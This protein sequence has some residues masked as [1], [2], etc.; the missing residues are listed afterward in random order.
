MKKNFAVVLAA[1]LF[2]TVNAQ[3]NLT[4]EEVVTSRYRLTP[5]TLQDLQWIAGTNSYS[6]V[7]TIGV[8]E[9][10]CSSS[11]DGKKIKTLCTLVELNAKI[12]QANMTALGPEKYFPQIYWID[13]DHFY[14]MSQDFKVTFDLK[15][16]T[17]KADRRPLFPGGA[18]NH[19]ESE[20]SKYTAFTVNNNLYV[21]KN[22]QSVQVTSDV[23]PGIVNGKSYHREE[24]GISKGTFWSPSGK[25]LAFARMDETMVTEYPIM[26]LGTL[27]AT[28]RM[29][30]YP[31]AGGNSHHVTIGVYNT[32]TGKTTYLQTGEPVEQY[33]T[34]IAWSPDNKWIY[35]AVVNRGQDHLWLNRYNAET[36]AFDKTLFEEQ[37]KE[38]VQPF[39][40]LKFVPSHPDQFVWN[41]ERDGFNALYLYNI[42]G[43]LI[44]QLTPT[45]PMKV[46]YGL[47][48][49][50]QIDATT[51][52]TEVYGFD[53]KGTT[54]YFQ[55]TPAGRI[56]RQIYSVDLNKGVTS[57]KTLSSSDGTASAK[58][59]KDFSQFI[60]DFSNL[61]TPR[62]ISVIKSNGTET[63]TIHT[64]P[65]PLEAYS[66]CDVKLFTITA[67]DGK[68]P[69]W[70]RL[71]LPSGFDST[72]KYPSLTYVYNG[73]NVQTV[74]NTW[75]AG[76]DLFLYYM[77]QQG[78]VV[79][80]VDGR[81]SDNRGL[82]FE[83][84]IHRH[85]G[86][87]EL[88]DQKKGSDYLKSKSWIDGN[89]MA[90]YGWSYGGFMTTSMLT[91][92]D[93]YRCGVA[94]GAVIDWAYYEVMYTERYMDT[95]AENPEGYKEA[96]T[97]NYVQNLKGK[98]LEIHGTS[99]DVVVWQHSL[100]YT[101]AA[102]SKGVQTD[103]Y[104]YPGHLHG[105]RGKDR[106]HLLTKISKYVIENTK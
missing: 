47:T 56:N 28:A 7:R 61:T 39:Y 49:I 76:N 45:E 96:N 79:F 66:K 41:S 38:W 24:F 85:L 42:N 58:F 48:G 73:P 59:S 40:T 51:I 9:E 43:T 99:D 29:I 90:V 98:L 21:M 105:V 54:V 37:D 88:A 78:F 36:G 68:T 106:I 34:N 67:A 87:N 65:D 11:G 5:T 84:A 92:S 55:G 46:N 27:P 83:Q 13:A 33:L 104:M 30:R 81:G 10:L 18:E 16:R 35:I 32:E 20:A 3:K 101:Q 75:K 102:I 71:I 50:A 62:K 94:G 89:R 93:V 6:W 63:G 80:T 23:N 64:A 31:M 2:L 60:C 95:P 22:G 57:I 74:V 8:G 15:S 44:R 82:D 12:Q 52:V 26:E 97:M 4:L 70:C 53:T 72:K 103:Y 86:T 17:I 25:S 14:F 77:A 1:F 19:D 69:L 91:R 100:M